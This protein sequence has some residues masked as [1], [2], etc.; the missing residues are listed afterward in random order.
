[1]EPIPATQ[2]GLT[3]ESRP[4]AIADVEPRWTRD[5]EIEAIKATILYHPPQ[6][7]GEHINITF[8]SKG[9]FNKVY[10][11]EDIR[12]GELYIMRI[13]LPVDRFHEPSAEVATLLCSKERTDMPVA[14]VIA[15][16][17]SSSNEIGFEWVLMS[18][19]PGVS[20]AICYL[21]L[22]VEQKQKIVQ[23]MAYYMAQMFRLQF[24]EMGSLR[25][26]ED[27]YSM[28]R[29][30]NQVFWWYKRVH[31]PIRKGPFKTVQN[32][33]GAQIHFML[34]EAG[35]LFA[36]DTESHLDWET[37]Y[38]I[39]VTN[40]SRTNTSLPE[41]LERIEPPSSDASG[42]LLTALTH[43]DLGEHNVLVDPI[44]CE[45]T[46]IIDWEN[47]STHPLALACQIPLLLDPTGLPREQASDIDEHADASDDEEDEMKER[48]L[49]ECQA[50]DR[51]LLEH[52]HVGLRDYFLQEMEKICPQWVKE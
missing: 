33:V 16:D 41:L 38:E 48:Q 44:T 45:I 32:W 34:D 21:G 10:R 18:F 6:S 23:Q 37:D 17:A 46:G 29:M 28:G 4:F 26:T 52:Q 22:P 19:L 49:W 35:K 39:L 3:W 11:I 20:L 15:Y 9:S 43:A 5:P 1:M 31:A 14:K 50:Y 36:K 13:A 27:G 2:E 12:D 47:V 42:N 7:D 51:K 8:L 24:N 40:A 30:V 25:K